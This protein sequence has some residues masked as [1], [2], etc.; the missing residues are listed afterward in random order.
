MSNAVERRSAIRA[1]GG[2]SIPFVLLEQ[3]GASLLSLDKHQVLFEQGDTAL[4]FYVLRTGKVKMSVY[5][6]KGKE[7]IQGQFTAGQ[8]FGEPPFFSQTVY[9]AS[10]VAVEKSTVWRCG[11]EKFL[12]LLAENP[13]IHLRLTETLCRRLVYK[14]MMLGELAVEEAE[15][16]LRTVIEYFRQQ[17]KGKDQR[18]R[19][20]FT[21][22]QLA[23]M[24]GLRVETVIRT[25]KGMEEA[26]LLTIIKGKIFW[27]PEKESG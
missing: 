22:Q 1:D 18:Y 16:R 13:D 11:Y 15:H 4:F 17:E 20:P 2:E 5:N 9:P 6:D 8:S 19:V 23:D 14:S 27:M 24:T 21:R 12:C 10:A 26:G 3:Y 25:I 7:F